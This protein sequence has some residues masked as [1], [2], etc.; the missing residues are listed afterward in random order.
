MIVGR[1]DDCHIPPEEPALEAK[2]PEDSDMRGQWG[3]R[4][5]ETIDRANELLDN[6]ASLLEKRGIRVDRPTPI[7]FSLPA[8][9]PDF[10]TESQFGCMPPR[11][12]LLTVGSE[13][14][15]ATMSYRCRWFEYLCYRPL[16][17]KYWVEDPNFR[18]EA[19][20]KPRL[21]DRDYRPDYLSEKIGIEKRL[22]WT[23]EKFFVT[24]EE[25]EQIKT[26]FDLNIAKKHGAKNGRN[27]SASGFMLQE[28]PEGHDNKSI[29]D[30]DWKTLKEKII[31]QTKD[32]LKREVFDQYQFLD[33]IFQTSTLTVFKETKLKF[34]CSCKRKTL[35][36]TLAK[37]QKDQLE[38]MSD[39][40]KISA[41]CQFCGKKF[42]FFLQEILDYNES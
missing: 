40:Q 14:L 7:D 17:E 9:T 13:I 31:E 38:E 12:V 33:N 28:L 5:Q 35:L 10:S 32:H 39:S 18:H 16:M 21:T 25:D 27:W 24:T 3:R 30:N 37:Y 4:P 26:F 11:D 36:Y 34:G 15:E 8:I 19:A 6:F 29:D 22:K 23:A 41:D 1:A 20:P 2:V 42:K